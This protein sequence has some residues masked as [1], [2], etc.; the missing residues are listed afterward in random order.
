MV[1]WSQAWQDE[2]VANL[3]SF[4]KNG[5][6]LDIGSGPPNAQSNSYF[7][8]SELGWKGVCIEL[9]S[10]Y[11]KLYAEKRTCHFINGDATQVKYKD[12]LR[13]LKFPKRLDYLSV[14]CDESS[15]KVLSK[16]PLDEYRFS[17]I[18]CENDRYRLGDQL[19]NEERECLRYYGYKLLFGDTL[20][21]I[22]CGL[23]PNLPFED[24]WVDPA[25]FDLDKLN[26][27]SKDYLYPDDIVN[28]VK[29]K[30]EIW[31]K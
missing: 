11:N 24:W 28:T 23:G 7:F 3:L 1:F 6:Y 17:I 29:S 20:V 31:T 22:G 13:E 30:K 10:D 5:F 25:I 15:S 16:L 18:T 21:P 26:N 4:K 2:F 8:D 12:V 27:I 19:R 14:D 9:G